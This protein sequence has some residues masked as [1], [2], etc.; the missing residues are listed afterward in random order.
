MSFWYAELGR[1]NGE[2]V[3]FELIEKDSYI[4]SEG[5]LNIWRIKDFSLEF[6]AIST[7]NGFLVKLK[8]ISKQARRN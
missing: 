3:K 1:N 5:Y 8:K 7:E 6:T 4:T 2:Y